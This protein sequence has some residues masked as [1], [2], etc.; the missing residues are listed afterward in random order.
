MRRMGGPDSKTVL[1]DYAKETVLPDTIIIDGRRFRLHTYIP[2]PLCCR[3]CQRYSHHESKCSSNI[4]C[5]RCRQDHNRTD[6][7][8]TA[9][10]VCINC[11]GPH[12]A[13]DKECPKYI[14]IQKALEI[15]ARENINYK[16]A[17]ELATQE[18]QHNEQN[19][20]QTN[21]TDKQTTAELTAND[22][23]EQFKDLIKSSPYTVFKT[24]KYKEHLTEHTRVSEYNLCR[25]IQGVLGA[26]TNK[27]ITRSEVIKTVASTAGNLLLGGRIQ[28][29]G[30]TPM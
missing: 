2:K 8:D 20:M 7:P 13:D 18:L 17:Y 30:N 19:Q 14:T 4:K 16:E 15:R 28:F 9:T 27:R 1:I 25:F 3:R 12:S 21:K 23:L 6:C 24:D 22:E 10:T 5:T 26:L 11:A 29:I